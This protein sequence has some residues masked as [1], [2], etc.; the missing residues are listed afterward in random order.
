MATR[1][2][3]A[4]TARADQMA[5]DLRSALVAGLEAR[6]SSELALI[7]H[8]GALTREIEQ[9]RRQHRGVALVGM[10]LGRSRAG[11][12]LL[13]AGRPAWRRLYRPSNS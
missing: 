9:V 11:R 12:T 1:L 10:I 8:V 5:Q 6:R 13:R 7:R 2:Q 3:S 4:Q